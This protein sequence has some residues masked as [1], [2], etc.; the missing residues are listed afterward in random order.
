MKISLAIISTLP[1]VYKKDLRITFPILAQFA[2]FCKSFF[3]D[4]S[5]FLF[6]RGRLDKKMVLYL[7]YIILILKSQQELVDG[8]GVC[9]KPLETHVYGGAGHGDGAFISWLIS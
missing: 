7:Y 2:D 8:C 5:R 6:N 4:F 1:E 3:E 9:G